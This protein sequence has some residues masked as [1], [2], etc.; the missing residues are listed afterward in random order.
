[1]YK[2]AMISGLPERF[3]QARRE[4]GWTQ[5]QIAERIG[6]TKASVSNFE[7]GSAS[8]SLTTLIAFAAETGV[9]LDWLVL[10]RAPAG[11]YDQRIR[12]LPDALREYV[13]A[14]LILAEVVQR[15]PA[16][17]FTRAP[18]AETLPRFSEMLLELASQR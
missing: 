12:E 16:I 5:T 3:R 11:E 13:M 15:R 10:G 17:Q 4:R 18:T 2:K 6:I 9:S 14:A 7:T 8:P 1:V